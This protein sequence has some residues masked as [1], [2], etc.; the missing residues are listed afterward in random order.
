MKHLFYV[1]YVLFYTGAV[2]VAGMFVG[3]MMERAWAARERAARATAP[4]KGFPEA[5]AQGS[6]AI[7]M[8]EHKVAVSGKR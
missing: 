4:N 2:F 1:A 6:A 8:S 3:Q 5:P 7:P